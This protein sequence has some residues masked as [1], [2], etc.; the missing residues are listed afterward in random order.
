MYEFFLTHRNRKLGA[1]A[2]QIYLLVKYSKLS[3]IRDK[4]RIPI[5]E[6]LASLV[7]KG[8]ELKE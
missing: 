2:M 7:I 8:K 6:V 4:T 5:L 1:E 3:Q